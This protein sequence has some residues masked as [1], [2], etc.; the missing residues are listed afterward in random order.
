MTSASALAPRSFRA[1]VTSKVEPTVQHYG[2]AY[3]FLFMYAVANLLIGF[4]G[5]AFGWY[6]GKNDSHVYFDVLARIGGALLNLNSGIVYLVAAKTTITFLR[7]TRLSMCVPFDEAMPA[8]HKIV[9]NVI[10]GATVLHVGFQSAN[11]I[12]FNLLKNNPADRTGLS[13]FPALLITGVILTAAICLMRIT[14]LPYFRKHSWECFWAIH[15]IGYIVFFVALMLHGF[16]DKVPMT[17]R[18]AAVPAAIYALD[19]IDRWRRGLN[20][21]FEISRVDLERFGDDMV[22]VRMPRVFNYIAGQYAEIKVPCVSRFQWHPFTIASSPHESE[23]LFFIKKSGNWTSKLYD[24]AHGTDGPEKVAIVVRG[25]YGAPAQHVGQYENVVLISGGVGATPFASI[26][27]FMHNWIR[28][29]AGRENVA[30]ELRSPAVAPSKE[31]LKRNCT[32]VRLNKMRNALNSMDE[33]FDN[34]PLAMRVL[35][36]LKTATLNLALVWIMV[37]RFAL[38]A[39]SS[40]VGRFIIA[41]P[42]YLHLYNSK[43]LAVVDYVL[44]A[45]LLLPVLTATILEISLHGFQTFLLRNVDNLLDMVPFLPLLVVSVVLTGFSAFT[46]L[47]LEALFV[48]TVA[49]LW[50]CTMLLM[51]WRTTRTIGSRVF[52]AR[53]SKSAHAK[54]KSLDFIWVSKTHADDQWLVK[55][56]LPFAGTSIVRLHRFITREDP[57]I[58]PWMSEFENIPLK[59]A[60]ERPD[61]DNVFSSLV[62]RSKSGTV[63]GVFF[64]GP[65]RMARAVRLSAMKAMAVSVQN[66]RERGYAPK[67]LSDDAACH[68]LDVSCFVGSQPLPEEVGSSY[69]CNVRI[70]VRVENFN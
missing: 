27:K 70:M 8:F 63:V 2:I 65:D 57:I 48:P 17:W 66:A 14:A 12:A 46:A 61:W 25:P 34:A 59:T 31:A 36:Y 40:I 18:Y 67:L 45:M 1:W 37:V 56:M 3:T 47:N 51:L 53:H 6:S 54:T 38:V 60:Y 55:E 44:A 43:T 28:T 33:V 7:R 20:S 64:C 32:Q 69:G 10:V 58:E 52:L 16:H 21:C 39:G 5:G 23:I 22:C 15:L 30:H 50:P 68:T 41:P 26:T 49:I 29:Y 4:Q 11:Y 9:G 35:F 42:R 62:E 24:L 13:S 19:R